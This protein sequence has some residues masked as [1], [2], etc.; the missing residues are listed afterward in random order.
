M[1]ISVVISLE[2]GM[3]MKSFFYQR[4]AELYNSVSRF[5]YI[6]YEMKTYEKKAKSIIL[7]KRKTKTSFR[8]HIMA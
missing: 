8:R 4:I 5:R 2:E 1:G 3:R 6:K 7:Q